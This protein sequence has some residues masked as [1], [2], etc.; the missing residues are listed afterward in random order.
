MIPLEK[1]DF[2]IL[3]ICAFRYALGRKTYVV[4]EVANLVARYKQELSAFAKELI[5]REIDEALRLN[6]AGM[7][8]DIKEWKRLKKELTNV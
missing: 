3:I 6:H 2:E 7:D 5:V 8:C 4:Y 1:T